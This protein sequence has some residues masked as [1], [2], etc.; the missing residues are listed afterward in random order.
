MT[1][2]TYT[3]GI[4]DASILLSHFAIQ[5]H[6][7]AQKIA[8][9]DLWRDQQKFQAAVQINGVE[10]PAQVFEDLLKHWYSSMESQIEKQKGFLELANAVET[11]AN[12]ILNKKKEDLINKM[13]DIA[14]LLDSIELD[15][16]GKMGP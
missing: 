11:A 13:H 6:K 9:T 4:H 1:D 10:V 5:D 8:A 12:E 2:S 3:F 16:T 14:N 15:V 7:T